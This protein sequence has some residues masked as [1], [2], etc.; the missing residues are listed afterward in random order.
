MSMGS[1]MPP[2]PDIEDWM[3]AHIAAVALIVLA[4]VAGYLAYSAIAS[5]I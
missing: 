2:D 4:V 1:L 5:A 3:G